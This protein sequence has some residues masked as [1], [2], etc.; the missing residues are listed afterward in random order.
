M[1]YGVLELTAVTEGDMPDAATEDFMAV[2]Q[3]VG[4]AFGKVAEI[5]GVDQ[6]AV[7]CVLAAD[8]I[9]GVEARM[10]RFG[11]DDR[12]AFTTERVGGFAIAKNLSQAE[13]DSRIAIVF[14]SS[15]WIG[16][17]GAARARKVA[18]MAHE[19]AHPVMTRLR[20]MSGALEGVV[21]PS[22]TLTEVARSNARICWD[23]FRAEA[24]ADVV[25]Q[26]MATADEPGGGSRPL[27]LAEISLSGY[28]EQ[29]KVQLSVAYP[30]WADRVQAY[31]EW[32]MK[33]DDMWFPTLRDLGEMRTL[34][35]MTLGCRGFESH[36]PIDPAVSALP[37][38]NLYFGEPWEAYIAAIRRL[39]SIT[40]PENHREIEREI[41]DVG[42]ASFKDALK[43]LGLTADDLPDRHNDV[44][45]TEPQRV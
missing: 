27:P 44:H 25:L 23:D 5:S 34:M 41:L 22:I 1:R 11:E 39:P 19:L 3:S 42:E 14:D 10:R 12:E 13:D 28:V 38:Y 9:K 35:V 37:A 4:P 6:L 2:V 33:L 24:I 36:E 20:R 17:D 15:I 31:R 16:M 45:V 43:A 26:Q 40:T 21:F 7:E 8:F 18:T 29:A 30:A 32:K